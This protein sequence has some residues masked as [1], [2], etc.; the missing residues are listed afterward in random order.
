M[1]AL[2]T[3]M[4]IDLG[5]ASILVYAKGKGIVLNEPS[6][7]AIDQNTKQFLAVGEEARKMLGRTPGNIIAMRPLRDG[8]ISDYEVTE[9]MLKYFIQKAIGKSFFKPRIIVCVPSGVTEVEKRAVVEAST[10]AGAKKTYLIEE[11]IAAA[12]GAG[13][14]ITQ[15]NG[16]MVV[17][18]GG[19]T[20]DVAVIS[21]GGMVVSRSIKVAGDE[22]DD[23]IIRY[24][25]KKHNVMIG[26]RSAEELKM[27]IGTAY[28]RDKDI[29]MEIRGRNL[30]TGLPKTIIVSS[31]EILE[32]LEEPITNIVDTV[33]AVLERTPP[34]LAADI[35][36]TGIVMTGGG[37]L[38][39]GLD[40]L[41]FERTGIPTR[42]ADDPIECVAIGTGKALDWVD[43]LDNSIVGE[44]SIGGRY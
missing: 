39:Y 13:I 31:E 37:A 22:C 12:I 4:G 11:P 7:V 42:I 14:D 44:E 19:G 16:N 30:V 2:K 38:L 41:I 5:T 27:K 15:P 36:N 26:E 43:V 3:D 20:T 17:D 28:K 33:H 40:K 18:I 29:T 8:V 10:Q 32:A 25:R 21:L 23:A 6:V 35:G 24:I 1:A 34:E 9:K